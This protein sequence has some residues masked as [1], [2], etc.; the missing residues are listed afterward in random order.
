MRDT[1]GAEFPDLKP[2]AGVM[3]VPWRNELFGTLRYHPNVRCS[4]CGLADCKWLIDLLGNTSSRDKKQR[5][6]EGSRLGK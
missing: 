6:C 2:I 4:V 3:G 5:V 1:I